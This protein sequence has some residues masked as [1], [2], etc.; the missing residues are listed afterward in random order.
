MQE[1]ISSDILYKAVR[2]R[3]NTARNTVVTRGREFSEGNRE[4]ERERESVCVFV[5]K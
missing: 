4:R 3:A 5:R 1:N 2:I